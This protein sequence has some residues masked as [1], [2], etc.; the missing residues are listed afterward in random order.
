MHHDLLKENMPLP[1]SSRDFV[2]CNAVIQH[3]STDE[4]RRA[5]EDIARVLKF[6]GIF[7][8]VFKRDIL[9]WQSFSSETKLTIKR[10]DD[11]DGA[12][13]IVDA[14]IKAAVNSLE[15]QRKAE[16]SDDDLAGLRLFHFFSVQKVV[17]LAN[18]LGLEVV[19]GLQTGFRM[20]DQ[21]IFTYR[22][23]RSI[24]TAAVFFR[25]R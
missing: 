13:K 3:F 8:V 10:V 11:A 15:D 17:S 7:L 23:G 22:S 5:F 24:P 12:I 25:R 1:E 6:D 14:P 16:L 9:D 19:K 20:M 18:E 2:F 4:T 21:A